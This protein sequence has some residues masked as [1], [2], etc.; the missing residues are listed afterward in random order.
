MP[1]GLKVGSATRQKRYG[2]TDCYCSGKPKTFRVPESR[3][4]SMPRGHKFA[5][6]LVQGVDAVKKGKTS[7]IYIQT[8]QIWCVLRIRTALRDSQLVDTHVVSCS[9]QN[10][11]EA[12]NTVSENDLQKL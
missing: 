12:T 11:D 3:I 6:K 8:V 5:R 7:Y 1:S 10:A 9:L 4:V 2:R